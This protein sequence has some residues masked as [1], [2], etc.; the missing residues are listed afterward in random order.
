MA[1][2]LAD[3]RPG[4]GGMVGGLDGDLPLVVVGQH[5]DGA[6][7]NLAADLTCPFLLPLGGAGGLLRHVPVAPLVVGIEAL[8]LHLAAVL[9]G[10]LAG[11]LHG[12]G[13]LLRHLPAAPVVAGLL[14]ALRLHFTAVLAGALPLA[15]LGAGGLPDGVPASPLVGAGIAQVLALHPAVAALIEPFHIV[16]YGQIVSHVQ[17]HGD[18]GM[19][20]RLLVDVAIL[21]DVHLL[22]HGERGRGQRH[23]QHKHEYRRCNLL[24]FHDLLTLRFD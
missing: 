6:G 3:L 7:L 8:R 23:D 17:L 9:A 21:L 18:A 5:V 19:L 14:D 13:G 11:A 12:A 2:D 1:A 15:L 24:H 4:A 20:V 10:A 16:R 22:A